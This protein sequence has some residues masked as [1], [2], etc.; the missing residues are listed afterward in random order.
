MGRGVLTNLVHRFPSLFN[1]NRLK[2]TVNPTQTL[3]LFFNS[4]ATLANTGQRCAELVVGSQKAWRR[5]HSRLSSC[6]IPQHTFA[7]HPTTVLVAQLPRY[8]TIAIGWPFH[9]NR[10]DLA[11]QLQLFLVRRRRRQRPVIARPIHPNPLAPAFHLA[12][13]LGGFPDLAVQAR[14]PLTTA[15]G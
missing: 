8:A 11:A 5:R 3:M 10:L 1:Q 6:M 2:I 15:G 7:V 4:A 14:S 9:G 13:A 12:S